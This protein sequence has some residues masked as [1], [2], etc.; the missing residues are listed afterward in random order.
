MRNPAFAG[1]LPPSSA[2]FFLGAL[3]KIGIV[4]A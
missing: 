3:Q 1:A 2:H 4:L